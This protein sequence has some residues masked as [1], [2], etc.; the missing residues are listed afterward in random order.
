[1]LL[2]QRDAVDQAPF[3]NTNDW[4]SQPNSEG[5]FHFHFDLLF[6]D[7]P[8]WVLS[9]RWAVS[10]SPTKFHGNPPHRRISG[11]GND[12]K[13]P[14]LSGTIVVSM[15]PSIEFLRRG[16]SSQ[17]AR[18]CAFARTVQ[19]RVEASMPNGT[20]SRE[21]HRSF[22]RYNRYGTGTVSVPYR[23]YRTGTVVGA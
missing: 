23:W 4:E 11:R 16:P 6:H 15:H 13:P 19:Y 17:G 14:F 9:L 21:R 12:P 10:R 1:M 20:K 18:V 7:P 2:R 8:K 3:C 5:C 22:S